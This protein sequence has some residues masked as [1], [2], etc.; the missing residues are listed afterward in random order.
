[1]QVLLFQEREKCSWSFVFF[2]IESFT[3]DFILI[4][5]RTFDY[6]LLFQ[7]AHYIFFY[8]DYARKRRPR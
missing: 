4:M 6:T 2:E 7:I 8:H 1:M 5:L 3:V